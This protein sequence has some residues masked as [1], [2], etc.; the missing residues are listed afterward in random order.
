MMRDLSFALSDDMMI[1]NATLLV[2]TKGQMRGLRA[3]IKRLRL[4][5]QLHASPTKA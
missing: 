3:T 5:E 1:N 4:C 2:F